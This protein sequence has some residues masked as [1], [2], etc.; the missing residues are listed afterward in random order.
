PRWPFQQC[1]CRAAGLSRGTGR[2][3]R[4]DCERRHVRACGSEPLTRILH[5]GLPAPQVRT[6]I[7]EPWDL[8][9]GRPALA[10]WRARTERSPAE[11]RESNVVAGPSCTVDPCTPLVRAAVHL[12]RR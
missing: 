7:L 9:P 6:R 4:Q 12:S 11:T 5:A 8:A 10:A 1:D 3:L 2:E